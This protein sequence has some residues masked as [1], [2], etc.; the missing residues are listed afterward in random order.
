MFPG[1]SCDIC[2]WSQGLGPARHTA[3]R[4]KEEHRRAACRAIQALGPSTAASS[5]RS[6]AAI[7]QLATTSICLPRGGD[8]SPGQL[9]L[10]L[11]S[12]RPTLFPFTSP[13]SFPFRDGRP[14]IHTCE[15]ALTHRQEVPRTHRDR[16]IPSDISEKIYCE[17]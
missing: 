6:S 3:L 16:N 4:P 13:S 2:R 10:P 9:P 14:Q 17:S 1:L 8:L 15:D 11:A 5:A 7:K 12:F